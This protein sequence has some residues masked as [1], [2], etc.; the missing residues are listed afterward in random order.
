MTVPARPQSTCAG[1]T[2]GPGATWT[3][4]S[5]SRPSSVGAEGRERA[6][7]QGGVAGPQRRRCTVDGSVG[8]RGEDERAVGQRLGSR[9]RAR[10]R[11][12]GSS[13]AVPATD[14]RQVPRGESS[15]APSPRSC[16]L[17]PRRRAPDD[18]QRRWG[19]IRGMCGRYAASREPGRPR[20]GVRGR[21]VAAA[22]RRS[23]P[24]TTSRPQDG[25]RRHRP[26]ADRSEPDAPPAARAPA[27]CDGASCRRGRR[28]RRSAAG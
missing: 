15:G 24:T 22:S 3:G 6:R 21:A 19:R 18:D 2:N 25:L 5:P 28:T 12:P 26:R 8:Q 1:P 10:P 27:A 4:P 9:A 13:P 17:S 11:R 7:H 20:R 14:G 16:P 23:G